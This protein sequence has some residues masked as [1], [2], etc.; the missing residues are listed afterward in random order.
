PYVSDRYLA[1]T[2]TSSS[3][4]TLMSLP[5]PDSNANI[6]STQETLELAAEGIIPT[7][8]TYRGPLRSSSPSR[9]RPSSPSILVSSPPPSLSLPPPPSPLSPP[10]QPQQSSL[11]PPTSP[12]PDLP[13]AASPPSLPPLPPSHHLR[14]LADRKRRLVEEAQAKFLRKMASK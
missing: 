2:L 9:P 4:T 1:G 13:L 10:V 5:N 8:E 7:A 6:F 3:N 14:L 11:D 12:P